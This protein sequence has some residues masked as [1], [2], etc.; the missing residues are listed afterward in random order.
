MTDRRRAKNARMTRDKE[1]LKLWR[2][3]VVKS[4]G[5]V[6]EKCGSMNRL[7]AHHVITRANK[8]LRYDSQNGVCLCAGHHLFFAHQ[9]PH[10][11]RD[12]L[13]EKRGNYWWDYIN[14]AS[15]MYGGKQDLCAI[16][17]SLKEELKRWS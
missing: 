6:C 13:T 4:A 8:R 9:K 10:E 1:A 17:Y 15:K 2:G 12:W 3:I 16:I 7:Q 11:F 14:T 5:G